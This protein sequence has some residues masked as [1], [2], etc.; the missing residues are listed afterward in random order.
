MNDLSHK[1]T[2]LY[3]ASAESVCDLVPCPFS[4]YSLAKSP[5]HQRKEGSDWGQ[6][7]ADRKVCN[8]QIFRALICI[9]PCICKCERNA[10]IFIIGCRV[11]SDIGN[12]QLLVLAPQLI[13]LDSVKIRLPAVAR[14]TR[15]ILRSPSVK[16]WCVL[17]NWPSTRSADC[18]KDERK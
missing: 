18:T 14:T 1:L 11:Q 5:P 9:I 8:N 7:S 3:R 17:S 2:N 10:H 16:F 13:A 15:R 6:K 4:L 12:V